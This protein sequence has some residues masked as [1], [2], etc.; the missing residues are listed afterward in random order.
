[1]T[2]REAVIV[3]RFQIPPESV[4]SRWP[5]HEVSRHLSRDGVGYLSSLFQVNPF[6]SDAEHE[7]SLAR[8]R[9]RLLE[10]QVG[11]PLGRVPGIEGG[12]ACL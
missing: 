8:D 10:E 9:P 11:V 12:D 1:M 2:A 5:E 3:S 7:L 6:R 4:F